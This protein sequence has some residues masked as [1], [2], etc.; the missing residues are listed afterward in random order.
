MRGKKY[1]VDG[2]NPKANDGNTGTKESPWKT[3]GRAVDHPGG[4]LPGDT[5]TVNGGVYRES[6]FIKA[7]GEP[8]APITFQAAI[9]EE[10]VIKG[11]DVVDTWKPTAAFGL[12][13]L[14]VLDDWKAHYH[15]HQVPVLD[16]QCSWADQVFVDGRLMEQV[17]ESEKLSPGKFFSDKED[18]KMYI[19]LAKGDEPDLHG[20]EVSTKPHLFTGTG[21]IM[22]PTSIRIRR[23]GRK[24]MYSDSSIYGDGRSRTT[25]FHGST[26]PASG[27]TGMTIRSGTTSS[28]TAGR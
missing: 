17:H 15:P 3:I 23:S 14:W 4:L 5:V 19:C 2:N 18:R 9:G 10:V 20:I 13:G 27:F 11:S 8:D 21:S 26:A 6:L 24:E 16:K 25:P 28:N 1:W 22:P 7:N 12:N